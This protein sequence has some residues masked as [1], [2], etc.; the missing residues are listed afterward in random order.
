MKHITIAAAF[1]CKLRSEMNQTKVSHKFLLMESSGNHFMLLVST[2]ILSDYMSHESLQKFWKN[3]HFENMRADFHK[4][5]QNSLRQTS[6]KMMQFQYSIVKDSNADLT[7]G[8]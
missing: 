3:S 6:P 2:C 4:R 5:C 7:V 8:N 1:K